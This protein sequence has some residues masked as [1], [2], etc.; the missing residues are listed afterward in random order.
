MI[1][2]FSTETQSSQSYTEKYLANLENLMKI[3]V[4]DKGIAGRFPNDD[5][6]LPPTPSK[7]GGGFALRAIGIRTFKT[8][9]TFQQSNSPSFGGGWGEVKSRRLLRSA[10]N[11]GRHF[12]ILSNQQQIIKSTN[13]QINKNNKVNNFLSNLYSTN[14]I[15]FRHEK[16]IFFNYRS[17]AV[18]T[19][20]KCTTTKTNVDSRF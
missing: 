18:F 16:V 1:K 13:N 7:R 6:H 14:L 10:R 11:D 5:F 2:I 3:M 12:I 15:F 8:V 4:Q 19:A 20:R 9:Q 17:N